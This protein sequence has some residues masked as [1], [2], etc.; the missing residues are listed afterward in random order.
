M[1]A[2]R[3]GALQKTNQKADAPWK[4][5]KLSMPV[6]FRNSGVRVTSEKP[7]RR[8]PM[9]NSSSSD[10]QIGNYRFFDDAPATLECVAIE[11]DVQCHRAC[12]SPSVKIPAKFHSFPARLKSMK[13][14]EYPGRTI[15][16]PQ[17]AFRPRPKRTRN[18]ASAYVKTFPA[19][20]PAS[21]II[22]HEYPLPNS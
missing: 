7:N 13:L 5:P 22:S 4:L 21:V 16:G 15:S 18:P 11:K 2:H 9:E 17:S 6:C 8:P 10:D 1:S 3:S 12:L 14:P 20:P 19:V